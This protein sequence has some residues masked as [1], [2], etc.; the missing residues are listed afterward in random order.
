[1]SWYTFRAD[2]V[3]CDNQLR[4]GAGQ[5]SSG[6]GWRRPTAR[7]SKGS[8]PPTTRPGCVTSSK[9][10]ACSSSR[11]SPKARSAACRCTFRKSSDRVARVPGLQPGT[12][13]APQ[14]RHAARAVARP[15]EA[16]RRV[17]GVSSRARR[18]P[19]EGAIGQRALGRVC[20]A[21]RSFSTRLHGVAARRRAQ[22]QPRCGAAALRRVRQDHG[23]REAQ[24]DLGAG[25]SG[26]PR[27]ARH[28]PGLPDR[29]ES[30][31]GVCRF[32]RVVRRRAAAGHADHPGDLEL[33]AQPVPA[34]HDR[35]P[36]RRRRLCRLDQTGRAAGAPRPPDA[37]ARRFWAR[38]PPSSRRRKWR[39]RWRRCSAAAC[40]W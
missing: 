16:A 39:A 33:R 15:A 19:R 22:R 24:D 25:V 20:R 28:R 13:H 6:A 12:G 8:I 35:P 40:R 27:D 21:R 11:C 29:P 23:E 9:K 31:A 18:R 7:L 10:R 37:A 38:S 4:G 3:R 14:G 17:A 32:L 36:G 5:W 2:N 1:M 26:H 30:R 34:H